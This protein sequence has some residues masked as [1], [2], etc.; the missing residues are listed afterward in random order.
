MHFRACGA[1][2]TIGANGVASVSG[3]ARRIRDVTVQRLYRD[4]A[5]WVLR[6]GNAGAAETHGIEFDLKLPL[7]WLSAA[8]S[9]SAPPLAL[10]ANLTR[11]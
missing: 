11:A 10:H 7:W 1:N 2:G 3:F 8:A 9:A 5:A 4:G 6:P